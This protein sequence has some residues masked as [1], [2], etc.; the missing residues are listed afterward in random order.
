MLK[1]LASALFLTARETDEFDPNPPKVAGRI[2]TTQAKAK[3]VRSLVEKCITIARKAM[4]HQQ[5]A[6]KLGTSAERNSEEW[7]KWRNGEAWQAWNAAV[8]PAVNLRRRAI[9]MLGDKQAV[10]ILFDIIAPRFAD[11]DGGYTRVLTLAT[12]RL[13]DAG[14]RS[15]LEFSDINVRAVAKSQKPSFGGGDAA[16]SAPAE[17]APAAEEVSAEATSDEAEKQE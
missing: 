1:N 16:E 13:G 11:R 3:E 8:A 9:Q 6:D 4:K 7:K 14:V 12:P 10:T 17:E 15:I 5:A 2:I